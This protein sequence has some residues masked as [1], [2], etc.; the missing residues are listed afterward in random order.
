MSW[1]RFFLIVYVSGQHFCLHI[2][3]LMCG[4][5]LRSFSLFCDRISALL[6]FR[7]VL[8]SRGLQNSMDRIRKKH[9]DLSPRRFYQRLCS[10]RCPSS[11]HIVELEEEPHN[12]WLDARPNIDWEEGKCGKE[13]LRTTHGGTTHGTIPTEILEPPFSN[14]H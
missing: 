6:V 14:P 2:G 3:T 1:K 5:S 12:L 9:S 10:A 13:I 8:R 7:N 11:G 4:S